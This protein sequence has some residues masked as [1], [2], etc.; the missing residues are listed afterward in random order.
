[1]K[2]TNYILLITILYCLS[3]TTC[4]KK[5]NNQYST[6][7]VN[8]EKFSTN[9]VTVALGKEVAR[10]GN[11]ENDYKN[12]FLIGFNLAYLPTAG[13]FPIVH[14]GGNLHSV[15]T[16]G[17]GFYYHGLFYIISD[18]NDGVLVASAA[19]NKARY[20]LAPTWFVNY[21]NSDDSVLIKGVFNE[22]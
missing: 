4:K 14:R 1:M 2:K 19:N 8:S 15:S 3:L 17:I 10:I 5:N 11:D 13:S 22:P 20:T 18:N 7:Y 21:D 12:N 6:W 9:K 16:V